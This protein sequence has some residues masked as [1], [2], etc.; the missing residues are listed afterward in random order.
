MTPANC[1]VTLQKLVGTSFIDTKTSNLET[2]KKLVLD[3]IKEITGT[4]SNALVA[5]SGL[6][7]QYAI[8]MGLIHE[9][10]EQHPDKAIKIMVPPNCYGG[11]NDQAR[12]VAASLKNVEVVDLHVDGGYDMVDSID[13]ILDNIAKEDA[14]PYIIAEIPT[15]PRVEVP[16]LIKLKENLS[17]ERYTASGEK[18]ID[19]VFILDQTFCP[20]TAFFR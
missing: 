7:M 12:R 3:T 1:V 15:N 9:A 8:V 19:P 16:D 17:K 20:N 2:N 11:T 14:V 5:S 10:L 18:A 4:D 6:S 13:F